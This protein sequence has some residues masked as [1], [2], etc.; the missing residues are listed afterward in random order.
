[1]PRLKI[2]L[3]VL[4]LTLTGFL[5]AWEF[6]GHSN[7]RGNAP[8]I[9][10]LL[11]EPQVLV[12]NILK[13]AELRIRGGVGINIISDQSGLLKVQ[14]AASGS[15]AALAGLKGGELISHV[16]GKPVLRVPF[17]NVADLFRGL[18][19]SQVKL[20]LLKPDSTNWESVTLRR[21]S[22]KKA[23]EF[24]SRSPYE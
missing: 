6:H 21:V 13:E 14:S 9:I 19:G 18:N 5:I 11:T 7:R 1:M 24:H 22:M 12:P 8:T 3:L 20:T 10:R 16:D 15:P 4:G 17:T 23:F 2:T